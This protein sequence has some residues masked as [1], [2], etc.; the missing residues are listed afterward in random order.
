MWMSR[1]YNANDP[2]NTSPSVCMYVC[3][4]CLGVCMR[5]SAFLITDM[6]SKKSG[7]TTSGATCVSA[8]L[9]HDQEGHKQLYI[10]NVGDSRAV[11]CSTL[12]EATGWVLQSVICTS[13]L[14]YSQH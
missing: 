3:H 9:H 10:A 1:F 4:M 8:L 13:T 6:E 7:I 5:H 14:L 12:D 2:Q 11:L